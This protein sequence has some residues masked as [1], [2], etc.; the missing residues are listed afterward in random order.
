MTFTKKNNRKL[1]FKD[2][3]NS[4]LLIFSGEDRE[5]IGISNSTCELLDF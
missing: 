4:N 1:L 3:I 5:L 2:K